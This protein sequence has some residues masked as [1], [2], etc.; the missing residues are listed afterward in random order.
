MSTTSLHLSQP[1][2]VKIMV[3]V[4]S[5]RFRTLVRESIDP[6]QGI[7][8]AGEATDG[9]EVLSAVRNNNFDLIILG[10]DIR[11]VDG[12]TVLAQIMAHQPTPI[13]AVI[14]SAIDESITSC[15]PA[16]KN[17]A[18]DCIDQRDWIT[19]SG[20]PAVGLEL[21]DKIIHGAAM[22]GRIQQP[23]G[24]EEHRVVESERRVHQH[25]LF[26]EECGTRNNFTTTSTS[27][28]VELTCKG[29]GDKLTVTLSAKNRPINS[30]SVIGC[31]SGSYPL[32]LDVTARIHHDYVG[33]NI[34]FIHD[35]SDYV[36]S[37]RDY[38]NT[39]CGI[40]AT[41]IE[42]GVSIEQNGFYL[43]ATD[44]YMIV[45]KAS[46]AY[47]FKKVDTAPRGGPVDLLM[48]SVARIF[49]ERT[50]GIILSGKE[51]DGEHGITAITQHGGTVAVLN[52]AYCVYSE[53]SENILRKCSIDWIIDKNDLVSLCSGLIPERFLQ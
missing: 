51:P 29:C 42:D 43:G 17:G 40:Q 19:R 6:H 34:I 13:I 46:G 33:T 24:D 25:A 20:D 18:I 36:S 50:I 28:S 38:I 52:S 9:F 48:T 5:D 30:I 41:A 12:M 8:L 44:E 11:L 53:M 23:A 47:R 32:L 10:M 35:K 31:G 16:I 7:E 22:A 2:P 15:L 14:D 4:R 39:V 1:P 45:E 37:L 49:S 26:C 21:I 27:G 3:A